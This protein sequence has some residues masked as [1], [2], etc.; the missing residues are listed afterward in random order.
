MFLL[1]LTG[2]TCWKTRFC[3]V[4]LEEFWGRTILSKENPQSVKDASIRLWA[5]P[6]SYSQLG[7][8]SQS[9]C[10]RECYNGF[11]FTALLPKRTRHIQGKESR[12]LGRFFSTQILNT[13]S[14]SLLWSCSSHEV[15]LSCEPLKQGLCSRAEYGGLVLLP[16]RVGFSPAWGFPEEF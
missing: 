6:R 12:F 10:G 7:S 1:W 8:A 14:Q 16:F 3:S 4:S 11:L 15:H 5:E 2:R 13:F 9:L